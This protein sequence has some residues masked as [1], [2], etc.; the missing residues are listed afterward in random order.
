MNVNEAKL[1]LKLLGINTYIEPVIYIREDSHIC[2]AEGFQAQ[3][4]VRVSLNGHSLIATLN[5]VQSEL[6]HHN[7]ASL[8]TYAW[9]FLK[10]KSGDVI[11]ISHPRPLESLNFIRS[12]IYGNEFKSNEINQISKCSF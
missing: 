11:T 10:A 9:S 3:A 8:S 5:T 6:L 1:K 2:N 4:R 7:E 12:K